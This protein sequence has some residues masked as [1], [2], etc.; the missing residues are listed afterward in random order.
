MYICTYSPPRHL[1]AKRAAVMRRCGCIQ[2]QWQRVVLDEGHFVKNA[3]T[4][5]SQACRDL[6]A[7]ARWVVSSTPVQNSITDLYG[8]VA[9]LNL[10]PLTE[11][12]VFRA[13]LERPIATNPNGLL[14]LKVL[15]AAAWTRR[16]KT[17]M[18]RAHGGARCCCG[19]RVVLSWGR[20]SRCCCC[21]ASGVGASGAAVLEW[22]SAGVAVYSSGP[23]HVCVRAAVG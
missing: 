9:F 18:V 16:M 3:T 5:Q 19:G 20:G 15:M 8:L 11:R 14:R 7:R 22:V 2:V 23:A 10:A 12:S 13:A 17:T 4:K 1:V 6:P 21:G